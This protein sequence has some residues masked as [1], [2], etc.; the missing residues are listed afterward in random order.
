MY[1]QCSPQVWFGGR[2]RELCLKVADHT[3]PLHSLCLTP[4]HSPTH[5]SIWGSGSDLVRPVCAFTAE[6]HK[7]IRVVAFRTLHWKSFI[8]SQTACIWWPISRQGYMHCS[9]PVAEWV[10]YAFWCPETISETRVCR[11]AL[12][13]QHTA[14]HSES[15]LARKCSSDPIGRSLSKSFPNW[16]DMATGC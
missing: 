6:A 12:R 8:K 3:W 4:S 15:H 16:P 10:C 13:F 11:P 7:S 2:S 5:P 14:A 9:L 1:A